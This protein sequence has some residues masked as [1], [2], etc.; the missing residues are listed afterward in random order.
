MG[1]SCPLSLEE[2][3]KPVGRCVTTAFVC[4]KSLICSICRFPWCKYSRQ[5]GVQATDMMPTGLPSL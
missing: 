3:R 2:G 4:E 5:G 1:T